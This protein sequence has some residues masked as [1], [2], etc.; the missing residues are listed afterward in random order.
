VMPPS[1]TKTP[2]VAV[3]LPPDAN[4]RSGIFAYDRAH[5]RARSTGNILVPCLTPKINRH[6]VVQIEAI[7]AFP[8]EP[9]ADDTRGHCHGTHDRCLARYADLSISRT[10]PVLGTLSRTHTR[11]AVGLRGLGRAKE[12]LSRRLVRQARTASRLCGVSAPDGS[13]PAVPPGH[14]TAFFKMWRVARPAAFLRS[15]LCE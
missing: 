7:G 2:A 14:L 4:R 11:R 15:R 12:R 3:T 9:N 5:P 13:A 10:L 8:M 6:S 1:M